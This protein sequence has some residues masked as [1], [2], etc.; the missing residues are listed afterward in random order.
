[1]KEAVRR[2]YRTLPLARAEERN[3]YDCASISRCRGRRPRC[4]ANR[5]ANCYDTVYCVSISRCRGRRPRRPANRKAVCYGTVYRTQ[6]GESPKGLAVLLIFFFLAK[7]FSALS[8][9]RARI[10]GGRGK[11]SAYSLL[12]S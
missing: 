5:K 7:F 6:N 1:M 8:P 2:G 10:R 4:P 11:V 9:G 12:R 3:L